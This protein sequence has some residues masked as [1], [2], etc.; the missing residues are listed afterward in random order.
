MDITTLPVFA[1]EAKGK[2]FEDDRHPLQ[3]IT[4]AAK[5][6]S[7]PGGLYGCLQQWAVK[8]AVKLE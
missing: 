7:S 3:S 8:S 1:Q 4:N 5:D 6:A 2:Q